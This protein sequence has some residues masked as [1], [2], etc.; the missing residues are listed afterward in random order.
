M[1][2]ITNEH[3]ERTTRD[4]SLAKSFIH[5]L[6]TSAGISINGPNPWDIQVHNEAF[7]NR[8]LRQPALGL[9]E[10]YMDG[11][12][13]CAHL[14]DFFYR[15][16]HA[17]LE[18]QLKKSKRLTLDLV[19]AKIINFQTKLRA[20]EVGLKH[21]NLGYSLFHNML[22]SRMNYTCGYW[23]NATTLDEAQLNKLDLVCQ[24]LQLKPGMRLLDIGCGWGGLVKYAAEKY[25]VS[26]VGVTISQD[27]YEYAKENCKGLPVEIRLQDYRDVNE[28]FDRI[29]SLGMFE[30][31]GHLNYRTYMKTVNQC[32]A[33]EGLF[34]LHTIGSNQTTYKANGWISKYIFPNGMIP[35][36]AQIAKAEEPLFIM[37]DWHN[38]GAD[39]DKTLMAWQANFQKNW[40][41][42]RDQF[43]NRFYRMWNYYLLSCAGAFR[44][45]DMQLWQ[46]VYSKRGVF[47][48]Y[49]A[50]R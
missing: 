23:K 4:N 15:I 32:L 9:G 35:S 29:A 43:D 1:N 16:L 42:I 20:K 10:S 31:V 3:L 38:F 28:Q 13:D 7:Y 36:I 24:K 47:G 37:E 49:Q 12:W 50:P 5:E 2:V 11:W 14:D 44:A 33:P 27:Q 41:K 19:L 6:L 25:G 17:K 40:E 30:H 26:A 8:A 45:R 21:Y 48:G 46:I 39:Y 34:L 18:Y 22:D